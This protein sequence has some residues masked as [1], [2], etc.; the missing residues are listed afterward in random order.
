MSGIYGRAIEA[1]SPREGQR[2]G[3][4]WAIKQWKR[5][6][7]YLLYVRCA[8]FFDTLAREFL[9]LIPWDDQK[10]SSRPCGDGNNE[11]WRTRRAL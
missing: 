11:K 2:H 3:A 9:M 1:T 10:T 7:H 6:A 4:S 8:A 5:L